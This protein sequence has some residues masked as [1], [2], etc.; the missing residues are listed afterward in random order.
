MALPSPLGGA[1]AL[2]TI[3]AAAATLSARNPLSLA[4][5]MSPRLALTP[6]LVTG[7]LMALDENGSFCHG[8]P[9]LP[10]SERY[11]E[12]RLAYGF[13]PAKKIATGAQRLATVIT[14]AITTLR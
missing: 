7:T 10:S 8:D 11:H 1:N 6:Q 4:M 3:A 12:L 9:F 2:S 5:A 14:V 13:V